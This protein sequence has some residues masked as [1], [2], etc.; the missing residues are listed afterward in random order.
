ML[1]MCIANIF[2]NVISE[3][4]N[5]E[6]CIH[7][8]TFYSYRCH[9]INGFSFEYSPNYQCFPFLGNISCALC[10]GDFMLIKVCGWPGDDSGGVGLC[11]KMESVELPL[12]N[13]KV[14]FLSYSVLIPARTIT[15]CSQTV[16]SV[17]PS[18]LPTT[19]KHTNTSEWMCC[20]LLLYLGENL[21]SY[22]LHPSVMISPSED[23]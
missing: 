22:N 12:L 23:T 20:L 3:Y 18:P 4:M 16:N 1:E 19:P 21:F 8:L 9:L 2:H 10:P 11:L 6:K 15:S 5:T 14:L 13:E 7:G 17:A